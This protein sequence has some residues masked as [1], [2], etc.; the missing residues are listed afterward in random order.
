MHTESLQ[1]IE[2]YERRSRSP[3]V[4][5]NAQNLYYDHFERNERRIT[6][7][8]ILRRRFSDLSNVRFIEI[9]AG[10]GGNLFMF[11]EAGIPW[12]NIHANDL[13]ENRVRVLKEEFPAINVYPGDILEMK[14]TEQFDIVLVS[15]VFSS[16]LDRDYQQKVADKVWSLTRSGG[17]VIWYDFIYDNPRN[18]DV[19]GITKSQIKKLFPDAGRFIFHS[20]TLAPP[21]G[22]LVGKLYCFFNVFPF[23]RTHKIVEIEKKSDVQ[24]A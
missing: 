15:T 19:A 8:E 11:K 18:Q 20:V 10:M 24:E 17:L 9:G 6:Y 2:R 21:I 14:T 22:R 12:S 23:L 13:L 7:C 16:I 5:K 4:R 1:I 3:V